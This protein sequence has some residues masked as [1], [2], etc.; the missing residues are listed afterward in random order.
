MKE[1]DASGM[2]T[3]ILSL[4]DPRAARLFLHQLEP[5]AP[6]ALR[7]R[8]LLSR[9][10]TLAA[11]SPFLAD[12]LLRHPEHIEWLRREG[13]PGRSKTA[14]QMSEELARMTTLLI[15]IA[16][17]TRLARFKNRELLRIYLRDCLDVASLSEVTQELSNLADA[18]LDYALSLAHQEAVNSHGS[19]LTRDER[20][21]IAQAQLAIV[22][23][24]KLGCRELNYASDIDLMFLYEGEGETAG[25]GR[26]RE[27]VISNKEFFTE[28][29]QKVVRLIGTSHGE[30]AVFRIDLR[31]RP[32]GRDGDLV[33]EVARAADYYRRKARP[34]ERQALIRAR[35]SA[36]S[37]SVV[38]D[39]LMSVRDI[40]FPR[41]SLGK[42]IAGVREAK[43][44]IDREEARRGGAFNVKLGPGGIREIEF[45]TQALQL[46]HGAREPWVR[47]THVLIVLQRLAEKGYLTESERARLSSA[48]S[49]LRTAEHRL[50]M[51]QGAQTHRL[52]ADRARLEMLARRAGY[53][54]RSD[55]ASA[56][57]ADLGAHTSAVRAVY[58]RIFA[59]AIEQKAAA[60]Q[61]EIVVDDETE[62]FL[63][64]AA[65]ALA[66][67]M[68]SGREDSIDVSKETLR[69]GEAI[70]L[71]L[72][73]VINPQRS[74]RNL[75]GW[76]NSL[77][78][79]DKEQSRPSRE[80]L[81]G[82]GLG[83]FAEQLMRALGSQYLAHILVS[84]PALAPS[85]AQSQGPLSKADFL[86]LMRDRLREEPERLDAL[87]REWHRLIVEIGC[88]DL[89][90]LSGDALRAIN[91][92]QTA[93]AEASLELALEAALESLGHEGVEP[94][95]LPFAVL[96]LGRLGHAGM[97]YGSDL[98]LL[99]VFDDEAAWPPAVLSASGQ[100]ASPQEFY[101]RLTSQLSRALSSITRE[102]FVYR[103]DL[104]LRPDGQSGPL[105][106]G[107]SSFTS[108]VSER[109]S[110]WEHSAYL[111]AREVAGCLNLGARAREAICRAAFDKSSRNPR[112]REEL[113]AI[114]MRLQR[115]KAR[116]GRPD[117]KWGRGGM[118]D[119][120][121]ITRYLQLRD[122]IYYPPEHGTQSLVK[123]LAERGSLDDRSA[124]VLFDGYLFL[125]RVDHW[126]RLLLDRPTP[127]LPASDMALGD[128]AR[129]LGL[130]SAEE[131]EQV[132]LH[133][134]SEIRSVF[135]D[136]MGLAE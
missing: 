102:G 96:G 4:P 61:I 8:R 84:R 35:A 41:D 56:F 26:R 19:P 78:T 22:S 47:S 48:Y 3:F 134:L 13:D 28:V 113:S 23:L 87:R 6:D 24:G 85:A 105:A 127:A 69:A 45:I 126:M 29:A 79:Y 59:Q 80:R 36:G 103:V 57:L 54:D 132:T 63:H 43:E 37:E 120:Y 11:Y 92:E 86:R 51:E 32:Y 98:D 5:L 20:G 125:R 12:T 18:I 60:G 15:G 38:S 136:V 118:T 106:Q 110:A 121:F 74:L 88:R 91:L 99:I 89:S 123:R 72:S 124:G 116:T 71:A 66:H 135:E 68:V 65:S 128:L 108:Y 67:L 112:L 101:A 1:P 21:R 58:N 109:A 97:D 76:A 119:V 16:P 133:H 10:L 31:L 114:R 117:I 14:E 9:L 42:A 50:Q 104:R 34:W 44:K 33:W 7:N 27:G 49:F 52:P 64:Q 90:A 111:K 2:E 39:F 122:R 30:G 115:E 100:A 94:S 53:L 40:I 73:R 93:L 25:A 83:E 55:P 17:A 77:A 62:R 95:A 46:A 107:L 75:V 130:A 70:R 82:D 129:A 81:A 131:V